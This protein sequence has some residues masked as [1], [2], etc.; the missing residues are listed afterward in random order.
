L[1]TA[2]PGLHRIYGYE[3][4]SGLVSNPNDLALMLNLI[5]PIAGCLIVSARRPSGRLVAAIAAALSAMAIVM[6]FSRA[7][8]LT[9]ATTS[10]LF[11][12][13]LL[14]RRAPGKA[15]VLLLAA[16]LTIP[17]L[18]QGYADRLSTI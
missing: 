5:L 17:Y 9:L 8:F 11:A 1:R 6:T 3:G 15:A 2:V 4:G 7:G 10:V 16:L 18:P 14:R 13:W 12:W